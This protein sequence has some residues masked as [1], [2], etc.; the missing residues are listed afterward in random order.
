MVLPG[1][2]G[3]VWSPASKSKFQAG[4]LDALFCGFEVPLGAAPLLWGGGRVYQSFTGLEVPDFQFNVC[5]RG[6]VSKHA[7]VHFLLTALP[8]ITAKELAKRSEQT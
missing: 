1:S 5:P 7:L 8:H 2:S 4:F 6:V 3:L